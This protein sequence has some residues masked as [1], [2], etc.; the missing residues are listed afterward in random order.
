MSGRL[1]HKWVH[2]LVASAVAARV[3]HV[4]WQF[5]FLVDQS[6]FAKTVTV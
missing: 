1:A 2:L 5:F 4:F 3:P 6:V